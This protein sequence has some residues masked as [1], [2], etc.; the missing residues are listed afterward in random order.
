MAKLHLFNPENDMALAVGSHQFTP[1]RGAMAISAAGRAIPMLWAGEGD[2]IY[3][4]DEDERQRALKFKNRYNLAGEP[5]ATAPADA[6]PVP[7]GWS[8]YTRN[9]FQKFGVNQ[10]LLPSPQRIEQLRQLSHRRTAIAIHHLLSTPANRC[11]VEATSLEQVIAARQQFGADIVVKLP[12]SSSGR[13]VVYSNASPEST[14]RGYVGG[15]IRRQGSVLVEPFY[16]RIRDFAMLF[17]C[18]GRRAEFR[19]LSM[20]TTDG[21]GFYAGNIV[22]PQSTIAEMIGAD[23]SVYI[24]TLTDTLSE[25]IAPHYEGWVG[26]DMMIC[27]ADDGSE[28]TVPCVEVNLRPTM[29]VA[30]MFLSARLGSGFEGRLLVTPAGITIREASCTPV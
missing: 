24:R 2:Y 22:A 8:I 18:D 20:F 30:A 19:G 29:G 26:V 13:G 21:R 10:R 12:W 23:L 7:W 27:R 17:H 14:F 9:L 3:V 28:M 1:P 6:T 25:V 4:A 11:P 15:M 16:R 5:V